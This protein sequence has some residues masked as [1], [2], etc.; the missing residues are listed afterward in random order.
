MIVITFGYIFNQ[1]ITRNEDIYT[2]MNNKYQYQS[3][4]VLKMH[5]HHLNDNKNDKCWYMTIIKIGL[6]F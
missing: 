4:K 2:F 6:T 1:I 3:N 5:H